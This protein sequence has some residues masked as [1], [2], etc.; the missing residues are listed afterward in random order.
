MQT[1]NAYIH[2]IIAFHVVVCDRRFDVDPFRQW[3]NDG[4][5]NK[6]SATP[7][8]TAMSDDKTIMIDEEKY[9]ATYNCLRAGGER[10]TITGVNFGE[11]Q[12]ALVFIDGKRC[13]D[14]QHKRPQEVLTCV[15][16]P[17]S[18]HPSEVVVMNGALEWL[19]DSKPYFAYA[20]PANT[21]IANVTVS[22]VAAKSMDVSWEPPM[23][24]WRAA[25]VTGY[26]ILVQR[27]QRDGT[28]EVE[29][30]VI[31]GNYTQTTLISLQTHTLYEV[32]VAPTVEDQVFGGSVNLSVAIAFLC[33][34]CAVRRRG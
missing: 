30:I 23:N 11:Y 27:V 12:P 15:T 28:R 34:S 10:I 18:A 26:Q 16:P 1:C 22:N 31:L 3:C 4:V 24:Y 19:R 20:A 2:T 6:Y 7:N 32:T 33:I 25:T 29:T 14:V 5:Q 9:A 17:G 13:T 21:S 8:F